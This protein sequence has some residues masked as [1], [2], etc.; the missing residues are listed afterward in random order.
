MILLHNKYKIIIE[1]KLFLSSNQSAVQ[2][3]EILL[4]WRIN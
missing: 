4:F 2:I 1:M 3:T